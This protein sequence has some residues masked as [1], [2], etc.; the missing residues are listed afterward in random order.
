MK[1]L[2]FLFCKKKFET[3][4]GLSG[5]VASPPSLAPLPL[6]CTLEIPLRGCLL[7]LLSRRLR[8]SLAGS[9]RHCLSL[10]LLLLPSL[11]QPGTHFCK[12]I[13]RSLN[14]PIP[15]HLPPSSLCSL[16]LPKMQKLVPFPLAFPDLSD[17]GGRRLHASAIVRL[18]TATHYH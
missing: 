5:N 11:Y 3:K 13:Y 1:V 16:L 15:S 4:P 17:S 9:P 18:R 7:L 8:R 10:A 6:H 14:I 12:F 2:L